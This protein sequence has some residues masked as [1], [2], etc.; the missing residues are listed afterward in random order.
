MFATVIDPAMDIAIQK[1]HCD[2]ICVQAKMIKAMLDH[3]VHHAPSNR[4]RALSTLSTMQDSINEMK[5]YFESL[6]KSEV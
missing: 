5:L 3:N 4:V 1:T 2:W 6:D